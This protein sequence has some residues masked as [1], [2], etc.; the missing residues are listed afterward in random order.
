MVFI[1]EWI[2]NIYILEKSGNEEALRL[3]S[4]GALIEIPSF[5][6]NYSG[7]KNLDPEKRKA[8]KK[9][10]IGMKQRLGIAQA[11]MEKQE[12]VILDE[13]MNGLDIEG[14]QQ[15]KQLLIQLKNEGRTIL[16]VS[17]NH[18][19]IEELCDAVYEMSMG[20]VEQKK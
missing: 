15:I 4:I 2:E 16:L 14:V 11:I 13:P 7:L 8:V 19:D 5:L 6:S 1:I 10:S 12:I 9:Y 18:E 20:K 17:H 3:G